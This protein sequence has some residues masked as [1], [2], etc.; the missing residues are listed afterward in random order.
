MF[1]MDFKN[2]RNKNINIRCNEEQLEF[3]KK[4]AKK[5]GLSQADYILMKALDL[6]FEEKIEEKEVDIKLK[7]TEKIYKQKRLYRK[8]IF[9]SINE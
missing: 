9:T 5:L 2:N 1:S 6:K 7:G 3:I 8:K 4:E